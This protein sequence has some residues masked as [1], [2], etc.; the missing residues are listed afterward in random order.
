MLVS[1][2][3]KRFI[4]SILCATFLAAASGAAAEEMDHSQHTGHHQMTAEQLA[5]LRAKI[6]L[7]QSLTDEQISE[8]MGRMR[9]VED[10]LSPATVRD[11]IGV[12]ALGHGYG[13]KGDAQFKAG[14]AEVA[15]THPTAV[16]LGMAMMDSGHIQRAVDQLEAA[17]AKTIVVLPTE[18]G[19][20]SNLTRQW[21]Y[22]MGRDDRSAYLDVPRLKTGARLVVART[23]TASPVIG[24][25]LAAN[26]RT[27]S[28]DPAREFAVVVAHGPT[29][30]QENQKELAALAGHA[31]AIRSALGLSDVIAVT[32]QDDAPTAVRQANVDRT[33]D[34]I[35]AEAARGKRVLVTPVLITS[36]GFV[37]MKIRKDLEG[38][39]FDIVDSGIT[40][41]PLFPQWVAETVAAATAS[42]GP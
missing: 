14:F 24:E 19:E 21:D 15:K 10:Y 7:Y 3:T 37:S 11:G 40:E 32:L 20:P 6:P 12:L 2:P 18:V 9:D 33:R 8:S 17:G 26:L 27:I 31:R 4:D 25:I 36:G 30:E 39:Q 38:L 34:R 1:R 22:I 35:R 41:S 23:P 42:Q 28:R 5:T 13:D 16:G 29:D